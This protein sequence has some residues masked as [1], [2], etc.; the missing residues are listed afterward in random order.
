MVRLFLAFA[1]AGIL[2]CAACPSAP[3]PFNPPDPDFSVAEVSDNTRRLMNYL[4]DQY[5]K[6]I[7]SGQM[8]T[9]WTTNSTMDMIARVYADTGK[10]PAIKGFD[11]IE[12]PHSWGGFGRE[13]IDEAIEWWEGRNRMD[14]AN[15]AKQ[16]LPD[17]PDIHGIVTFCW[18]WRVGSGLQFYTNRTD[19]RI[20]MKDG[21]LDT[22]SG[23]FA[24]IKADLDKVAALFQLLKDRDIPVLWRPLHEAA[25]NWPNQPGWFWWGASGPEACI[26]LWEYM[27]NYLTYEKKLNNLIWVWN[28]QHKDWFPDPD[29]VDIVGFDV[30]AGSQNYA[31]QL[32]KFIETSDMVPG[33]NRIVAMTENG[34][35]PDPDLCYK[36]G[37]MWSWFMTWN[38]RSGSV[39]GET[40]RDNFWAGEY[41]NTQAHKEHV[42]NHG[43]VIT[44]DELPDLTKYRLE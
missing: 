3:I 24:V 13:Q 8:D 27:H 28:G 7:I 29:T 5:G 40:H 42:Y 4:I 2:L 17:S 36:D 6:Y 22:S 44:L 43:M 32:G 39:Q 19:F 16:L 33:Q 20:P 9:S 23:D 37:A 15:P 34:A 31:S 10:Y 30:Y 1:M 18:H 21:M 38:D 25:G 11:L 12:L 35:F 14:G 41:H 26:A